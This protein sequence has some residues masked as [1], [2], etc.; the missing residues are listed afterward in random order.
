MW[1]GDLLLQALMGASL[2]EVRHIRLE[3]A[4]ELLFMQNQQM[5]DTLTSYASQETFTARLGLR[6]MK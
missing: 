5:I 4:E 3:H 1:I 6:G 2:I